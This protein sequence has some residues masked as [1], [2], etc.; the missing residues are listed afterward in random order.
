MKIKAE[1]YL[2]SCPW[3]QTVD[4]KAERKPLIFGKNLDE[5]MFEMVGPVGHDPNAMAMTHGERL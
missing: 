2:R 4:K 5:I 1:I 3:P